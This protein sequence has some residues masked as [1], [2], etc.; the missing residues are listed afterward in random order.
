VLRKLKTQRYALTRLTAKTWGCDLLWGR[1]I[2]TMVIRNTVAFGAAV[3]HTPTPRGAAHASKAALRLDTTQTAYAR[4][5]AGAY[6]TTSNLAVSTE[7]GIPPLDI[8]LNQRAASLLNRPDYR[9]K[10]RAFCALVM[11]ILKPRNGRYTARAHQQPS[12]EHDAVLGDWDQETTLAEWRL[13]AATSTSAGRSPNWNSKDVARVHKGL[14]RAQSSLLVQGRTGHIGLRSY[15]ASMSLAD[16]PRCDCL[17]GDETL[18]HLV[19]SCPLVDV[20]KP[21][22]FPTTHDELQHALKRAKTARPILRWVIKTRR[23]PM[24][25]LSDTL[26]A[27]LELELEQ[28]DAAD[29]AGRVDRQREEEAVGMIEDAHA[30]VA[31]AEEDAE[32]EAAMREV[33]ETGERDAAV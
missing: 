10:S 5:V 21:P 15:L 23:I 25:N 6:R 26:E 11:D 20:P 31:A 12:E 29:A 16:S 22:G 28:A 7:I 13:R 27:E 4:V 19:T 1:T 18:S 33:E 30:A 32:A 24:Y 2:Y 9:E 3:W 14:T 8:Y 17:T